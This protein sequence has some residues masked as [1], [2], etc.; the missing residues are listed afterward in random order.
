MIHR[1]DISAH[2]GIVA[3]CGGTRNPFAAA[4]I[5]FAVNHT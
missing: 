2:A 4:A 5:S 3:L 1:V